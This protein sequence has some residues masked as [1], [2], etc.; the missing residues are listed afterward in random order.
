MLPKTDAF[1]CGAAGSPPADDERIDQP[2]AGRPFQDRP[3]AARVPPGTAAG[4][5][6]PPVPHRHTHTNTHTG[7]PR[8]VLLL[9]RHSLLRRSNQQQPWVGG[10]WEGESVLIADRKL[11]VC[12]VGGWPEDGDVAEAACP[13]LGLHEGDC[14]EGGLP[15]VLQ[16]CRGKRESKR[17]SFLLVVAAAAAV[18]RRQYCGGSIAAAAAVAAAVLRWRRRRRRWWWW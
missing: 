5:P 6:P 9:R 18:L 2:S 10:W 11:L 7:L 13:V 8:F 17:H 3:R 14:G 1:P 12:C 4:P 15:G 16:G